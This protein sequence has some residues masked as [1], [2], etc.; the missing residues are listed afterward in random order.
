MRVGQFIRASCVSAL[1]LCLVPAP[2]DANP[3][4]NWFTNENGY[5]FYHIWW[6][7][8]RSDR[9]TALLLHCGQPKPHP[10]SR[11]GNA[12]LAEQKKD[13]RS[14]VDQLMESGGSGGDMGALTRDMKADAKEQLAQ[15]KGRDRDAQA[16]P[17]KLYDYSPNLNVYA[18]PEGIHKVDNGRFGKGLKFEGKQGL[19]LFLGKKGGYKTMD[20]WFK[21]AA[22]PDK[23]VW[24]MGTP[25]RAQLYLLPDGRV[26]ASFFKTPRRENRTHITSENPVPSGEWRHIA[27]YH[28]APVHDGQ[29]QVRLGING[30]VTARYKAPDGERL[31]RRLV[32]HNEFF[33]LG[34][35]PDGEHKYSGLVDEV[36][37]ASRRRYNVRENWPQFDPAETE[38]PIPFGPPLFE[39]DRR[40]FHAGFKNRRLTVH[41]A[42]KPKVRWELGEHAEFSDYQVDTPFGQGV[43]LDPAMS[44]PRIPIRGMSPHKGTFEMWFQP[45]NWDHYTAFGEHISW[46]KNNMSIARFRGRDTRNGQIVTFMEVLLPRALMGTSNGLHPGHWNHL[47]WSWSPEH[48]PY[49]HPVVG[50]TDKKGPARKLHAFCFGE[51]QW[52]HLLVRNVKVLDHVKPLYLELGITNDFKVYHGQRPAIIVD[53]VIGHS[54]P[55]THEE[56][57]QAPTRWYEE[58]YPGAQQTGR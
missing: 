38:R 58:H 31:I 4:E 51:M 55:L 25:R 26:R 43:L 18:L 40:V 45:V 11:L 28:W 57:K 23:P 35:A 32:S 15:R 10:W 6:R 41:P 7:E 52:R 20:G 54:E 36:R 17:G 24:L 29:A 21:S 8:C 1:M 9:E 16:P 3:K 48:T 46:R 33:F 56:R 14:S 34:A 27:L 49:P 30:R 53:E 47:V 50:V 39:K 12:K 5:A 13:K 42:G 37:I 44:F 2:A 22:L 19:R